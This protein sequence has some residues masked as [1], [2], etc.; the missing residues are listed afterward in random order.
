MLHNIKT[1]LIQRCAF[2]KNCNCY[3]FCRIWKV[4]TVYTKYT[5]LVQYWATVCDAGP[6]L[7]HWIN[8]YLISNLET[9]WWSRSAHRGTMFTLLAMNGESPAMSTIE[10]DPIIGLLPCKQKRQYLL[11]LQVGRYC[12]LHLKNS[13]VR[14]LLT[15]Q[16]SWNCLLS[17][18][19][20]VIQKILV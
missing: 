12:L 9:K 13:I 1:T 7:K 16:A 19:S 3:F 2:K 17:F 11:T 20:I 6:E 14:Y 4:L 5:I 18:K 10:L 8:V 15:L